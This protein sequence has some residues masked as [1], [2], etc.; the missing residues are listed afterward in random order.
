M[1]RRRREI[2]EVEAEVVPARETPFV[3]EL[4]AAGQL[5]GVER[6]Y[7]KDAE[8]E[9]P[10]PPALAAAPEPM[11][12]AEEEP[13][14]P[15]PEPRPVPEPELV[16]ET[17]HAPAT[18]S[19]PPRR[20]RKRRRTPSHARPSATPPP[21]RVRERQPVER[22]AM[23]AEPVVERQPEH[24]TSPTELTC[25]IQFWRGYLKA[26]FFARVFAEDGEPLAVAESPFFRARGNGIPDETDE[27]VAA[28][29]ALR[30]R[31]EASG[32]QYV[33]SGK[34]WF[35]DTYARS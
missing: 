4:L 12:V 11:P 35:A 6:E 18:E 15:E 26:A 29:R 8:P 1:L 28:Y 14:A 24:A 7:S 32:W 23:R 33:A 13:R 27:A 31:L 25:E 19:T 22:E 3:I 30:E 16:A 9:A 34:S 2:R 10:E 17:H 21:R 5:P 20:R